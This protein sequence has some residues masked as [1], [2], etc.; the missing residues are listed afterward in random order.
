M[1]AAESLGCD[2]LDFVFVD[3]EH[4]YESVVADSRA[5]L[6]KLRTG[7]YLFGHDYGHPRFPGVKQAFDELLPGPLRLAPDYLVHNRKEA[8]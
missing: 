4:G 2:S 3:A 1:Q 8:A 7:G 6:P 5:W